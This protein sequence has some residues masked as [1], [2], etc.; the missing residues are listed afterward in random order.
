MCIRK[1]G[2]HLKEGTWVCYMRWQPACA[3]LQPLC[4]SLLISKHLCGCSDRLS[5]SFYESSSPREMNLFV[6]KGTGLNQV[7]HFSDIVR[8]NK[9]TLH[10]LLL[11]WFLARLFRKSSLILSGEREI[12]AIQFCQEGQELYRPSG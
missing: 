11:S 4:S 1:V 9:Y 6:Q 10:K 2:A 7:I 3:A 12:E 5:K 8:R